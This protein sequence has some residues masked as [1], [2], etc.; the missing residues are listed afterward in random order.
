MDL[1][2]V[3]SAI[4]AGGLAGQLTSMFLQNR[5]TAKREFR[6]WLRNERLKVFSEFMALTSAIVSRDDFAD[7]PDEIRVVSQKIH[8]LFDGGEAPPDV[9]EAMQRLFALALSKKL[10]QVDDDRKW[11]NEIREEVRVVRKGFAGALHR[12]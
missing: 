3:L 12:D 10:G 11:R 2:Q 6:N 8:M 7:W 9:A 5:V 4:L 1:N